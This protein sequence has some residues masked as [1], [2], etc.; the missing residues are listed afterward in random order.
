MRFIEKPTGKF[1]DRGMNEEPLGAI[2]VVMLTLDAE[3]SLEKS[4]FSIYKE[5]PVNRLIVCDGGSKDNTIKILVN[6]KL[7]LSQVLQ[8]FMI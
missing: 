6:K 3:L 7:R 2:D 5:I 1:I 8:C 4:L